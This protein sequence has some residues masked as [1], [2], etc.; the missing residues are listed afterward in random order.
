MGAK[1]KREKTRAPA[2]TLTRHR[3]LSTVEKL[4]RANK[5][6]SDPNTNRLMMA[7]AEIWYDLALVSLSSASPSAINYRPRVSTSMTRMQVDGWLAKHVDKT[8]ESQRYRGFTGKHASALLD[9]I[10]VEDLTIESAALRI[11]GRDNKPAGIEMLARFRQ[12]LVGF[13][14]LCRLPGT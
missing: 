9:A 5:L 13:A 4:F 12:A 1:A 2:V 7:A 14:A 10:I 6:D 8:T 3:H 11:L